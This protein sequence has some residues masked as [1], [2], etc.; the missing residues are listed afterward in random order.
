MTVLLEFNISNQA[1]FVRLCIQTHSYY[2]EQ[3]KISGLDHLISK[4]WLH[5]KLNMIAL[6]ETTIISQNPFQFI[7]SVR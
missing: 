1:P 4:K 6:R 2:R 5:C 3:K 7:T